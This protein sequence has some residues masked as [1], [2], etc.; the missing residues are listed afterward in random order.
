M[1]VQM[2]DTHASPSK[3]PAI[4]TAG[5]ERGHETTR[6]RGLGLL[7]SLGGTKQNGNPGEQPK[8]KAK[9][10]S[11]FSSRIGR[12]NR[13]GSADAV[14]FNEHVSAAAQDAMDIEG[15]IHSGMLYPPVPSLFAEAKADN[16]KVTNGSISGKNPS[17]ESFGRI[18]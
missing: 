14:L 10:G 6:R 18:L 12:R 17:E 7:L 5:L 9:G 13:P 11:W 15:T 8:E 3:S 1:D 16:V 4:Y 2:Q